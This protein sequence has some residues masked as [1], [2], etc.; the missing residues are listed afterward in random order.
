MQGLKEDRI[1]IVSGEGG[2]GAPFDK[3]GDFVG[4]CSANYGHRKLTDRIFHLCCASSMYSTFDNKDDF[5][6]MTSIFAGN[7]I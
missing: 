5:Y 4:Q 2:D 1:Q 7:L 3:W 6:F